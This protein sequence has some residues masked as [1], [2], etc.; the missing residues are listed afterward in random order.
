MRLPV[1]PTII[2][3]AAVATMIA[4]G[5]WQLHRSEWKK[6]LMAQYRTAA[7]LP[8]I[9]WPVTPAADVDKLLYRRATGFCTEVVAWRAVAGHNVA[10]D[11][12]WSHIASCRT[13]GAEGPGMTVDMGWSNSS[14]APANW[15]GGEI[16]GI[17]G[18]D[19]IA[20]IR[21]VSGRPAP[22]LQASAPPSPEATPNNHLFYAIQWF[23]F[24]AAAATIYV[25]AL[26]RRQR[27]G[28]GN[29]QV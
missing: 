29:P 3:A 26:R 9:A 17:I 8:P 12:G 1:I 19:R 13:G 10:D 7:T 28:T 14:A 23:F 2:V 18:P 24:A 15:K 25:L 20:R 16:A 4:L 5:V 21:L 27:P 11:A 6:G 22:G